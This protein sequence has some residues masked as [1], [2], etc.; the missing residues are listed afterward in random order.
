MAEFCLECFRGFEPNANMSN[1]VLSNENDFC[2][3][4]CEFKP[5]VIKYDI[6]NL[7]KEM[8]GEV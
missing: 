5:V 6:D 4:C 7:L 3:G 1:V 2:E 8:A